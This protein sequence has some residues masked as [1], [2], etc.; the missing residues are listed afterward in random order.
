MTL[1]RR[2]WPLT[3]WCQPLKKLSKLLQS[4]LGHRR[5]NHIHFKNYLIRF[6]ND[7]DHRRSNYNHFESYL[8]HHKVI[9]T[10]EEKITV[11]LKVFSATTKVILASKELIT[12]TLQIMSATAKWSWPLNKWSQPLSKWSKPLQ[13]WRSDNSHHENCVS[14]YKREICY[15]SIFLA[16]DQNSWFLIWDMHVKKEK[17][18]TFVS[19]SRSTGKCA[20]SEK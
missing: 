18:G 2:S 11:T 20:A 17:Y 6:Q 5:S 15:C 16:P 19:I 10:T 4:D 9:L 7:H 12:V 1:Q 3:N 14:H 13:K 8:S